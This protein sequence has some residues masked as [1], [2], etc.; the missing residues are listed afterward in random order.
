MEMK[1]AA[2]IFGK[3]ADATSPRYPLPRAHPTNIGCK[4]NRA[5]RFRSVFS[6]DRSGRFTYCETFPGNTTTQNAAA[7]RVTVLCGG[8]ERSMGL[9][10]GF[11]VWGWG[12]RGI[13]WG[14]FWGV[15]W[16]W[17]SFLLRGRNRRQAGGYVGLPGGRVGDAGASGGGGMDGGSGLR[18]DYAPVAS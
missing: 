14:V 18:F 4:N 7:T 6:S 17:R 1:R 9:T 10:F 3:R 8:R 5:N 15:R 12:W 2:V 13:F 16:A 11:G